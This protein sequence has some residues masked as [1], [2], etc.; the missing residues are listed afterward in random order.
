MANVAAAYPGD[1]YVSVIGVDM[2]DN[3]TYQSN[4]TTE[5]ND[6]LTEPFG[7]NWLTQFASEHGKPL[8][9]PEWGVNGN[10]DAAFIQLADQWFQKNNVLFQSYWDSDQVFAGKLSD[11]SMP[12][13]AAAYL[14]AFGAKGPTIANSTTSAATTDLQKIDPFSATTISDPTAGSSEAV[15]IT[16]TNTSGVATDADGV[17]TGQGLSKIGPGAY[18][19]SGSAAAVTAELDALVFTPTAHQVASGGSVTTDF[20]LLV[21]DGTYSA[22][23]SNTVVTTATGKWIVSGGTVESGTVLSSGDTLLVSSGGA[24]VSATLQG[25]EAFIYAGGESV[26]DFVAGG[27][28]ERVS[29]GGVASG[30]VIGSGGVEAV[31]SGGLTRGAVAENGGDERVS[32]GGVASGTVISSGGVE[33]AYS[34]GLANGSDVSGGSLYVSSGVASGAKV[35]ASGR[36][37]VYAGGQAVADLLLSGGVQH[38]SSGGVADDTVISN[39]GFETVYAGGLASGSIVAGSGAIE[40]LLSGGVASGTVVS[41]AGMEYV[42]AEGRAVGV[43]VRAGGIERVWSGGVA[44]ATLVGD[45][46]EEAV[47]SGGTAIDTTVS[48]GGVEY[49]LVSGTASGTLVNSGGKEI[50]SSGGVADGPTV[51]GGVLV[52]DGEVTIT[53]AGSLI[54]S[55]SGTGSIIENGDGDLVLSTTDAGFNGQVVIDGG[56]IELATGG[57]IGIGRVGFDEPTTGTAVLQIDAADAPAAGGTFANVISNFNGANEDI[58]L[59]S[60][61]YVSGATAT[62]VG[63][64]LVLSDGGKTYTFDIAGTTADAYP[65][66]SDGHGG[67]LIDPTAAAPKAI[68][69]KVLAF[70]HAAAA[71]APLDAAHAVLASGTTPTGQTLLLHATASTAVGQM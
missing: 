12:A 23:N 55:L 15:T 24:S 1:Q 7:L 26:A 60:V 71:F 22:T 17:L 5:F 27:G 39:G 48:S 30:T 38:V 66:L 64:T 59:T 57:A 50:I 8:A 9:V 31:Y 37:I 36:A 14:A 13:A 19:L 58:D 62:V 63:S 45:L 16:L 65:V 28:E 21:S 47:Y 35:S 43:I 67:T 51:V 44:S 34:S 40:S 20:T 2:Y 53:G 56:T 61:A 49:V 46:G 4:S 10:N 29:S 68:D 25:G 52:D 54:G 18:T 42:N 6:F 41:S 33:V 11:G 69:P 3:N 70:A 32:S